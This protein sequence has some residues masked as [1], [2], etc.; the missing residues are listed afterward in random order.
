MIG[1]LVKTTQHITLLEPVK[2]YIYIKQVLDYNNYD[3]EARLF[4]L[5]NA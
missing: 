3:T 2:K 4:S 1:M 5:F